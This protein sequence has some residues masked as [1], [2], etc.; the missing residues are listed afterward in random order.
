MIISHK[1][2]FIFIKT[3]KTAGT[4]I[5][6]YLSPH[7][8]EEDIVTTIDSDPEGHKPRNHRDLFSS[9][10]QAKDVRLLLSRRMWKNY[11]KF[12]VERNPWD[13]TLSQY[14]WRKNTGDENLSLDDYFEQ[15]AWTWGH[16]AAS[17]T[18]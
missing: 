13:K 18:P 5:E 16:P 14:Y 17:T 3:L 7:C 6:M 2:K 12:C 4:S 11:F 10:I 9:H 15:G 1:Y 8:G